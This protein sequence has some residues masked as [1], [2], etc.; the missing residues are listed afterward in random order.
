MANE[1]VALEQTGDEMHLLLLFKFT[2]SPKIFQ[3]NPDG[4]ASGTAVK[5]SPSTQ[6]TDLIL[7]GILDAAEEAACDDGSLYAFKH[8]LQRAS[9]QSDAQMLIVARAL[10]AKWDDPVSGLVARYRKIYKFY[11][12]KFDK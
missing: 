1:I 4:T 11:G 10:Y 12:R 9:G 7:A 6:F 2:V 3:L 5:L 8:T